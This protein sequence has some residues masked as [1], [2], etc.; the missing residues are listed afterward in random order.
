[1]DLVTTSIIRSESVVKE[2]VQRLSSPKKQIVDYFYWFHIL[3]DLDE[4]A[5]RK[6]KTDDITK[7][8]DLWETNINND[9]TQSLFYKKNLAI[10][11]C[12]LLFKN[13]IED[14]LT[15]S[16]ELW[17]QLLNSTK[18]WEYFSKIYKLNDEL[19]V[20]QN[21]ISSFHRECVSYLSKIYSGLYDQYRDPMY[22][23]KF[24]EFFGAFEN[25]SENSILEPIFKEI[26]LSVE[27]LEA[28]NVSQDGIFDNEEASQINNCIH[29]I[30]DNLEKLN[31]LSLYE[32]SQAKIMR[33]RAVQAIR[34]I[35]ID[36]HNNLGE[37][38][39]AEELL[40][41]ALKFVGT[42]GME[43]AIEN[44]LN[45]FTNNKNFRAVFE[46]IDQLL[47]EKNYLNAINL[48][49]ES[50]IE[51]IHIEEVIEALIIKKKQ[52]VV[53]HSFTLFDKAKKLYDEKKYDESIESFTSLIELIY[54]NLKSFN[55]NLEIINQW[56]EMIRNSTSTLTA[57]NAS[58]LDSL[59]NEM[60]ENINSSFKDS[61]EQYILNIL[62]D[63][64]ALRDI[65]RLLQKKKNNDDA[66]VAYFYTGGVVII[67]L[68]SFISAFGLSNIV[69]LFLAVIGWLVILEFLRN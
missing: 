6:F 13:S 40:K 44:D 28:M 49:H 38:P 29:L 16:L 8:I 62:I 10:L 26:S 7:V 51:N 41:I 24:K 54:D 25:E 18:F 5:I 12:N 52:C 53:E 57:G 46:P 55:V 1:L 67:F 48:I 64:Q 33:D 58:N 2:A 27:K 56:L 17:S 50:V 39:K 11:Y 22:I 19:Q 61:Y 60:Q 68:Y 9:S 21:V 15:R 32:N 43:K 36:I 23:N 63:S 14:Y 34:S 30:E 3:N 35:S 42:A 4:E 47:Q 31:K 45:I 20:D 69:S 65:A 66:S 37:I 59:I